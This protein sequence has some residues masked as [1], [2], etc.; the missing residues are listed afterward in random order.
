MK[1]FSPE[2]V[3]RSRS[4]D[5]DISW[6]AHD[7]W[8]LAVKRYHR[9]IKRI[10]KDFP[11]SLRRFEEAPV[12]LHDAE[13][14]SMGRDG[15]TFVWVLETEPPGSKP[16]VLTFTLGEAPSIRTGTIDNA[17]EGR[18]VYWLYE[19][20]DVDRQKRC[21]LEALLSNGWV[22]KLVFRDFRYLITEPVLPAAD[23]RAKRAATE[24][25]SRSA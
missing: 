18:P 2:L 25:V 11:E 5:E 6:A 12:C 7:E 23:G 17:R 1:Y 10:L 8:E 13:V 15:D 22:V 19:E 4:E 16:V 24:A 3:N 20:W 14:L 21:T 9:R